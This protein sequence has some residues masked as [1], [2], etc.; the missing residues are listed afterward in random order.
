L[1]ALI[2]ALGAADAV[3]PVQ[4][5]DLAAHPAGNLAQLALLVGGGLVQ[6]ADPKIEGSF[7]HVGIP[8]PGRPFY[9]G[10]VSALAKT[11]VFS[12]GVQT[13]FTAGFLYG[14]TLPRASSFRQP[15]KKAPDLFEGLERPW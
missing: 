6:R 15:G 13:G 11:I 9:I 4:L 14:L 1:R 2:A 8:N 10:K 12:T 5:D 3:V 7:S